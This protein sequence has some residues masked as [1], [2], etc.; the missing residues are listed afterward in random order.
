MF[1]CIPTS[2]HSI[3]G[4]FAWELQRLLTGFFILCPDPARN[5]V[6]IFTS[7]MITAESS[8]CGWNHTNRLYSALESSL[9]TVAFRA[10]ALLSIPLASVILWIA[11]MVSVWINF[12]QNRTECMTPGRRAHSEVIS[13]LPTGANHICHQR[14]TLRD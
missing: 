7:G 5:K 8:F 12:I 13:W 4:E 1:C 2:D 3:P 10:A 9:V 14:H 11:R 6:T